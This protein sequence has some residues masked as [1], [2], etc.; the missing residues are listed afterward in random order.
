MNS[1]PHEHVTWATT[2]SGWMSAFIEE[3]GYQRQS[4]ALRCLPRRR[5]PFA[6]LRH[7]PPE[8]LRH[9]PRR[10]ARKRASRR[11]REAAHRLLDLLVADRDDLHPGRAA[12]LDREPPCQGGVEPA[13]I[14]RGTT[15]TGFPASSPRVSA[16]EPSGSTAT[17]RAP[18]DAAATVIPETSPPPPTGTTITSTRGSSSRIS[19]PT[20][21]WPASTSG[22]SNGCTSV[23]PVSARCSSR[24]RNAPEGPRPPCRWWPRRN[25]PGR[26]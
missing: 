22:S 4:P 18:R 3:P 9:P 21:P 10:P 23:A 14:V 11:R 6:R 8:R 26:A 13:T 5:R 1:L 2:Y 17:I 20:V 19:S 25:A 7:G 16:G 24:R 15:A 12:D